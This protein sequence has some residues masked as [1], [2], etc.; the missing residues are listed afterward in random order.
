M[1]MAAM[2]VDTLRKSEEFSAS[3]QKS[4]LGA[5]FDETTK[6]LEFVFNSK[7]DFTASQ[8]DELRD[9]MQIYAE[10]DQR[11]EH[12]RKVL[13]EIKG[14]LQQGQAPPMEDYAEYLRQRSDALATKEPPASQHPKCMEFERTL[15]DLN[16]QREDED[17]LQMVG[18]DINMTCPITMRMYQATGGMAPL[19]SMKCGHTYSKDGVAMLFRKSTTAKCPVQGCGETITRNG[20]S[21]DREILQELKRA[22]DED[23]DDSS[24]MVE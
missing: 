17:E 14:Q 4:V 19:K 9:C 15:A 20:L 22:P 10:C 24:E 23:D 1:A 2:S 12:N 5:A 11:V 8:L 6:A 7:G 16:T 13:G 21:P 3:I 18:A